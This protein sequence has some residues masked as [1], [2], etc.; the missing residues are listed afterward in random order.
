MKVEDAGPTHTG[1]SLATR[2]PD[3]WGGSCSVHSPNGNR[4]GLRRQGC[5]VNAPWNMEKVENFPDL[6]L[7]FLRSFL[8]VNKKCPK[9]HSHTLA[10]THTAKH[11]LTHIVSHNHTHMLSLS[12][13]MLSHCPTL[14]HLLSLTHIHTHYITHS[15]SHHTYTL[16]I[17]H[18]IQ[19]CSHIHIHSYTCSHIHSHTSYIH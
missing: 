11:A 6:T 12:H 19:S 4:I 8:G 15:L 7:P 5:Q 2:S 10:L 17:S 13:N 9:C 16:T 14:I 18:T 3:N 1:A